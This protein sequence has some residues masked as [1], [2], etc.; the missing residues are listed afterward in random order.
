MFLHFCWS[1]QYLL[2]HYWL[3]WETFFIVENGWKPLRTMTYLSFKKRQIETMNFLFDH[4]LI[5]FKGFSQQT[6]CNSE[7]VTAKGQLISKA[8]LKVFIWTK[9]DPKNLKAFCPMFYENPQ[10]RNPSNFSGHFWFKWK[11]S[12]LLLRLTDL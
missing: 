1:M 5:M 10:G 4:S 11:L 2:V 9:N 12:Y 6:G 3:F 8:N 7:L